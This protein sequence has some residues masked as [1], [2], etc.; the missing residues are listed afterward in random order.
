MNRISFHFCGAAFLLLT[1]LTTW[2]YLKSPAIVQPPKQSSFQQ[3]PIIKTHSNPR[4]SPEKLPEGSLKPLLKTDLITISRNSLFLAAPTLEHKQEALASVLALPPSARRDEAIRDVL[5]KITK[6][7]PRLAKELWLDWKHARTE[8]WLDA[9]SDTCL[10]LAA[11][12][13]FSPSDFINQHIPRSAHFEVW[14]PILQRMDYQPATKVFESLPRTKQTLA[15]TKGLTL[16][17]IKDDPTSCLAW[18]DTWLP[19]LTTQ[20][21]TTLFQIGSYWGHAQSGPEAFANHLATYE[22]A[23]HP[24]TREY[25]ARIV[26]DTRNAPEGLRDS[27]KKEIEANKQ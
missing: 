1:T 22:Q 25:L 5:E 24:Q 18:L 15:A 3:S 13:P 11:N 8:P 7:D 9:A 12:D 27:F 10:A 17:W 6:Q 26:L 19:K 14:N 4:P 16:H 21:R 23:T 2:L 20:Q